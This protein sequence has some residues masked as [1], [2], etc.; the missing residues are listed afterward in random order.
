[1][2]AS[3]IAV[4]GAIIAAVIG[5]WAVLYARRPRRADVEAVDAMSVDAGRRHDLDVVRRHDEDARA[6]AAEFLGPVLSIME[7]R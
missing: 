3:L 6:L 5:A 4:G 2:M 7:A 1:M